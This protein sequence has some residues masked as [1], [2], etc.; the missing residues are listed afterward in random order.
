MQMLQK[1]AY[2]VIDIKP[3]ALHGILED[4]DFGEGSITGFVTG[5]GKELIS[6]KLPEGEAGYLQAG[7]SVFAQQEFYLQSLAGEELAG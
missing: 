3:E 4:I 7:E 2:I 1:Q 6:E 5:N